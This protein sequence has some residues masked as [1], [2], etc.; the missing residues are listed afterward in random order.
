MGKTKTL[1]VGE[2]DKKKTQ[3]KSD[4]VHAPGL[5][6]GQ[7]I[8]AVE[9]EPIATDSAETL[10]TEEK[11]DKKVKPRTRGKKYL[12]ASKLIDRNK[13]YKLSDAVNLVKETSISSF[14]GSVELHLVVKKV[15]QSVNIT[16]PHQTGKTKK[17]EVAS[18]DT[19]KRLETGKIDFDILLATADMMPKLV[20][21]ARILGP[22]GL[23]PNPKTGT[24]IKKASD[25]KNF[26]ASALTIK[27]ERE[28]PVI[29]TIAGKVS[30]DPKN[31]QENIEI[32]INSIGPKQIQ[33]A[34]LVSSMGPSIKLA[35]N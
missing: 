19:V 25:A 24:I 23:M 22:K 3:K 7:R 9:A 26:S 35:V 16:L 2:D 32:I 20:K 1:M 17:I 29:H 28:R 31:L 33:K 11:V 13:L 12:E 5:K 27:T 34:Y 8:K 14:D 21:F 18:D 10:E 4:K 6:G 15:G 30:M